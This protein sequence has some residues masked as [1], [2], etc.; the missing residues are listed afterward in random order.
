[1][2]NKI[3]NHL[4]LH[5]IQSNTWLVTLG[6]VCVIL[7]IGKVNKPTNGITELSRVEL[8]IENLGIRERSVDKNKDTK[9]GW[10]MRL[11]QQIRKYGR[12]KVSEEKH[13]GIKQMKTLTP[14]VTK[15]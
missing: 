13:K 3:L 14:A 5:F 10:E 11:K 1:M 9:A 8:V 12:S 7:E 6:Y 15:N 2:N 4:T